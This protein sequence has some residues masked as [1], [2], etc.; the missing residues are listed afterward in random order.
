MLST[1]DYGD[2]GGVLHPEAWLAKNGAVFGSSA[3]KYLDIEVDASKT[4]W[5]HPCTTFYGG[6]NVFSGRWFCLSVSPDYYNCTQ[7]LKLI[8]I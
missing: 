2:D 4:G 6:P 1:I 5:C 3:H 7:R 8:Q